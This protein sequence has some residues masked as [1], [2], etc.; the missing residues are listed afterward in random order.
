VWIDPERAAGGGPLPPGRYDVLAMLSIA[1]FAAETE[2][3]EDRAPFTIT[4]P[5][6]RRRLKARIARALRGHTRWS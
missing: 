4:V 6:A 1:G 2:A 5:L 3:Q